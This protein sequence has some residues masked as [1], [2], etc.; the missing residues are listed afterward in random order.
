MT[1]LAV[2]VQTGD[3]I[4]QYQTTQPIFGTYDSTFAYNGDPAVHDYAA[5]ESYQRLRDILFDQPRHQVE[6]AGVRYH[7]GADGLAP[8]D[9]APA[10]MLDGGAARTW[11]SAS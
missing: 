10:R 4:F 8:V 1:R 11:S 7:M 5:T 6:P 2:I 3:W 9:H